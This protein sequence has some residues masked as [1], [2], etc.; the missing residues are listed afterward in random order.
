MNKFIISKNG[1][2]ILGNVEYHF[3]LIPK[4][5]I[6]CHGGGF[7]EIDEENK[8]LNLSGES[9]DFGVP[10]FEYLKDGYGDYKILYEGSKVILDKD[11]ESNHYTEKTGRKTINEIKKL[12]DLTRGLFN[13]FKFNDGYEVKAKNKKDAIRKNNAWKRKIRKPRTKQ[14]RLSEGESFVTSEKEIQ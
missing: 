9:S 5:E 1:R 2:L 8:I 3:E 13:S 11:E 10:K 4:G 12:K 7:W 14:E 6:N